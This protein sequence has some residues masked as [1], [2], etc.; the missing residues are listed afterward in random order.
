MWKAVA[1]L[2]ALFVPLSFF[3][4]GGGNAILAEVQ[5]QV[6][7]VHH[8]L[9]RTEFADVFAI[10]RMSP[11]PGSL[12]ITLIGWHVAGIPGA[13]A[14]TV[15]IFLPT[16]ILT[17]FIAG[18]WSRFQKARWQ[19][20]FETGLKPVAAGL[21]LAGVF[22]LFTNLGGAPWAQMIALGSTAL[23]FVKR[24]NPFLLLAAG[25]AI[26]LTAHQWQLV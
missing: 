19:E 21:V 8:W 11:G 25:A 24:T 18:F 23:L 13:V 2:L 3:T 22:V 15:G 26:F 10:S 6:V 20:S 1:S 9:T 16:I 12:Y 7:G 14:A 4:I 5:R 17:Y